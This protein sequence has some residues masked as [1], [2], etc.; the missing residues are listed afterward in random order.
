MLATT[1]AAAP[2]P[3]GAGFAVVELFTSEGCSSCPPA[4]EA[5]RGLSALAGRDRLPLYALEWHVDYWDYLGWKDP[6]GSHLATLRQERYARSLASSMFTPEAIVNGGVIANWAGDPAELEREARSAAAAATPASLELAVRRGPSPES[7]VVRARTRG[8]PDRSLVLVALTEDGLASRPTAGENAGQALRHSSVVR[9]VVMLPAS[10]GEAAL[11]VPAGLDLARASVVGLLQEWTMRIDAAA[12]A[13]LPAAAA[14]HLSG[15][16]T[17]GSGRSAAGATV[18]ACSG[19]VCVLAVTDSAG[20]F[21]FDDLTPG[22]WSLVAGPGAKAVEV[23][24]SA[25]QDLELQ[26]PLLAA[27]R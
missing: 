5:L 9:S 4:D 18:Q 15:R 21:R 6:F 16:V 26:A 7:V 8:A 25:G 17:D 20:S 2:Q 27:S 14:A 22:P 24:V 19:T 3:A 23:Q 13:G 10:G 1:A 12:R 11:A